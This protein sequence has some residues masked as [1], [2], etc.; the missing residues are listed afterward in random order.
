[1]GRGVFEKSL[2][3]AAVL[4]AFAATASAQQ[5]AVVLIGTVTDSSDGQAVED[6]VVTVTSPSLQGE[7]LA[8]TGST[9]SYRISGLPPGMYTLRV[10]SG[11]H[12]PYERSGMDLRADST[13]RVNVGLLP[14][15]LEAEE[16]VVVGA[17]PSVDVGSSATGLNITSELTSRVPVAPPGG[18]GAAAR[19]FE[20]VAEI[21]PTA[22][23]DAYGVSILG[24]SSPEN[25]YLIDGQVVSNPTFGLLGTPLSMEFVDEVSVLT[26]GYM[27]E[28]GRATGGI[29]NA[30]TKSGSNEWHASVFANWAPG[31]LAGKPRAVK[32]A[33]QT[34]RTGVKL[35]NQHDL[36]GDISGPLIKDRLW[37]YAGFDWARTSYDLNRSLH[38]TLYDANG[39]VTGTRLIEGSEQTFT[40]QQD[41][42]Q[43]I[44]KLDFAASSRHRFTL[45]G[46]GTYPFS[47]GGGK[48][49]IDPVTDLPE[50]STSSGGIGAG[51]QPLNGPYGALA[52]EYMGSSTNVFA[53]WAAKLPGDKSFFDTWAGFRTEVAGRRPP[54]GSRIG[55]ADGLAGTSNVWWLAERNLDFFER[56]PGDACAIT[57]PD[58]PLPCPVQEYRTGGSEFINRAEVQRYQ[59]KSTFTRLFEALGSH[60]LKI[61]ADVEYATLNNHKAYSGTRSYEELADF[62]IFQDGRVQG[63]LVGPDQP[64][65]LASIRTET[66][67]VSAGAFIQDSWTIKD[68]LTLNAGLRYD[69]QLLFADGGLAMTLPNQISPR[70]GIIWDFTAEGRSKIYV[71]WAR[72]YEQVPMLMLDRYLS[73]EPLLWAGRDPSA[74]DLRTE[75]N[76]LCATEAAALPYAEPPGQL[77]FGTGVA[78]VAVDPK[79]KPPATDEI[80]AGAEYEVVQDGRLGASYTRRRLVRTIEDMSRDEGSTYF[81]GNPG[82]GIADDFPRAQRK[83]DAIVTYFTKTFSHG[84]VAQASYTLSWLRGNYSGLFRPEDLQLDP[85]QNSDFD[86]LSTTKN[87]NGPLPGDRRHFVKLHGGKEISLGRGGVLT[88]GAAA[89]AYSGEP[90]S[91]FAAHPLY[92]PDQ[93]FI[94]PR[95]EAGRLPWTYSVDLRLGYRLPLDDERGSGIALTFDVFNVLNFQRPIARDQR[96]T[97]DVVDPLDANGSIAG[98]TNTFGDPV[99]RNPNFGKNS[100]YQ[101]PRIFRFGLKG[102]Y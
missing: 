72:Y 20:S 57:N 34:I 101:A 46:V 87:R 31:A 23:N 27:P 35:Q 41:L 7:E 47:G 30:I 74:C 97:A 96:Y 22:R 32:T 82:E 16:V 49:G 53:K 84:W 36:G 69:A 10:E 6:A 2:L 100:A 28:Y 90:Y 71:N 48:Y 75:A 51:A 18:R 24:A 33:G 66:S 76:G 11:L 70:G 29:L 44:A 54:D 95:G 79:L 64:V 88:P 78:P 93:V 21:A 83:Y 99:T 13:I 77:Y 73:G 15:A 63:Y 1:M 91:H 17:T 98:L 62:G 89:R 61:G 80:V 12:R 59:A 67:S 40:A 9:G 42:F 43:G 45:T 37:L 58:D 38:R 52:H 39:E 55:S 68:Q 92:G 81:F 56:V 25:R 8:V 60:T 4:L 14:E 50:I 3:V 65:I 26:G 85:H 94:L 19:S 86:I 5:G 102:T